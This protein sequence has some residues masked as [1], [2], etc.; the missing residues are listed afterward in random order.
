MAGRR[1]KL[2]KRVKRDPA[3]LDPPMLA[4]LFRE[5]EGTR[6]YPF[7]VTAASTGCRRGEL[8]ALNWAD[9]DFEKATISKSLEQTRQG[10]LRLKCTKS[11]RPRFFGLDAF[12]LE[13]PAAHR[14][15]QRQ[16]KR[17]FG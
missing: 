10:G 14:E 13:V 17:N 9:V 12:A 2:P 7:I 1:V 6:A 11:G 4:R 15:E 5:A 3:V 8:C 16:D